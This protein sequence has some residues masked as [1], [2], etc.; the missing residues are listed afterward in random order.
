MKAKKHSCDGDCGNCSVADCHDR[1]AGRAVLFRGNDG[2]CL[3]VDHAEDES[4]LGTILTGIGI[5]L[6]FL[7]VLW[8]A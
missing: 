1:T 2:S 8:I 3:S 6:F 5:G 4:D 7:A